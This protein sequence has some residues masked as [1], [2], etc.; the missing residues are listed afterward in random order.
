MFPAR[1]LTNYPLVIY[2]KAVQWIT[3]FVIPFGFVNYFPAAVLLEKEKHPF[4]RRISGITRRL[5][6]SSFFSSLIRSGCWV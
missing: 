5:S 1:N 3:A 6:A 4:S 2:P